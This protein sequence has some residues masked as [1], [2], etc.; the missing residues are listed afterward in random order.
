VT[1]ETI[2]PCFSRLSDLASD[3]KTLAADTGVAGDVDGELSSHTKSKEEADSTGGG[4]FA[5]LEEPV[6]TGAEA[7]RV[8]ASGARRGG[9][10]RGRQ[11]GGRVAAS[12]AQR[13]RPPAEGSGPACAGR[14]REMRRRV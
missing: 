6:W 8:A 10:S 4:L 11:V 12:G 2:R 1:A 14:W 5:T 3:A 9:G 13:R 7:G